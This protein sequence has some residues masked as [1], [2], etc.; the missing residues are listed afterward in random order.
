ML[1]KL[2][3]LLDGLL[4]EG[5]GLHGHLHAHLSLHLRLLDLANVLDGF[6]L[7]DFELVFAPH[8]FL[9]FFVQFLLHRDNS[10]VPFFAFV[11]L[12]LAFEVL[13]ALLELLVRA[14]ASHENKFVDL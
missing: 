1:F 2:H 12:A 4:G 10:T 14:F 9:H 3:H 7:A 13:H 8:L 6:R 11:T 5:I